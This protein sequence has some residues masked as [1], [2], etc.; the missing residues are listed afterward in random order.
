ML[1][2]S[3]F[4]KAVTVIKDHVVGWIIV[5]IASIFALLFLNIAIYVLLSVKVGAIYAA[6]IVFG[7][8]V[9]VGIFA[10]LWANS[11]YA[12]VKHSNAHQIEKFTHKQRE[13][14]MPL[15]LTMLPIL[16]RRKK[17]L[18]TVGALAVGGIVTAI[19]KITH[20]HKR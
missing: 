10:V 8:W 11:A 17:I 12:R 14:L 6:L 15:A 20:K 9:L 2:K 4:F 7:L 19:G 18:A 13:Y 1:M 5:V 16:K 3:G